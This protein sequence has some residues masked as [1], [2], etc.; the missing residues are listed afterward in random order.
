MAMT[1]A[2]ALRQARLR[3]AETG[4]PAPDWDAERL[5]RHVL[6]WDRASVLT[7][8]EEPLPAEAAG[9]FL[10]LVERRA[11]REPLQYLV[12]AQHFWRHEFAVTPD[13]L[14]PRPETELLVEA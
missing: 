7:R 5:L 13:V 11:R 1:A 2:E 9:R 3:L 8:A 14:I 6:S 12:G 4:V 10:D